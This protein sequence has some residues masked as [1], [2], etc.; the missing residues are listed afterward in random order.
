MRWHIEYDYRELKDGLG[1]DHFE[2]RSWLGR[3]RHRHRPGDLHQA[4]PHPALR[5]TAA[6][7]AWAKRRGIRPWMRG[8]LPSGL[9][10][11]QRLAKKRADR[12]CRPRNTRSAEVGA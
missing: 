5:R 8:S 11:L 1:L 7:V 12:R 10:E 2:G 9:S 4:P 6:R 3:H